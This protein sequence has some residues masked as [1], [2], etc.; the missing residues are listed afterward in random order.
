[1]TISSIPLRRSLTV[2]AV[3]AAL[4]LGGLSIKVAAAWTAASAPLAVAPVSLGDLE[5]SLEAERARSAELQLELTTLQSRSEQLASALEQAVA[6]V[7]ADREGAAAVAE[8]MA[9][10]NARLATLDVEIARAERSLAA[11]LAKA[12]SAAAAAAA[13]PTTRPTAAPRSGDD[14]DHEE[15]DGG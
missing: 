10:A 2:V 6:R 4:I 5:A 15:E 12:R 8:R 11:T 14:D 3:V 9:E 13:P 7:A 1:M